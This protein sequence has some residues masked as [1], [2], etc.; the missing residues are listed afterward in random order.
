MRSECRYILYLHRFDLYIIYTVN[1]DATYI[2]GDLNCRIADMKD[3]I[4]EDD[5]PSRSAVDTGVNKHG[6]TFIEFLKDSKCC[7]LNGRL[8]PEHDNFTS[9]STRGK[10]VVDYIVTPHA[11]LKTC[12]EFCVY[13]A[14]I[15]RSG[16]DA[17]KLLDERSSTV[18]FNRWSGFHVVPS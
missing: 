16:Y 9:I 18:V 15:E 10:A 6:Q 14:S 3:Y 7:V 17:V 5:I 13:T 12:H 2:C 11:D 8:N 1:V 4:E